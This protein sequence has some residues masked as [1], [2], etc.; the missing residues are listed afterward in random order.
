MDTPIIGKG[1]TMNDFRSR[2][3][4]HHYGLVLPKENRDQIDRYVA[5]HSQNK[6]SIERVPFPRQ[7]DFW[8]FSI[9]TALAKKL[10]PLNAPPSRWGK[11]FIY[12]SQSILS[13]DLCS[14]LAIIAIARIGHNDPNAIDPKRIID[15]ANRLAGSGCPVVL[16]KLSENSLRT[17][18]LDRVIELARS[19]KESVQRHEPMANPEMNS[20]SVR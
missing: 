16:K 13:N 10:E 19:L 7:V 5:M 15:L 14:L 4:T 1:L 3:S 17:T 8:A 6:A 2:F 11:T 9:A 12:T 18:P 20:E